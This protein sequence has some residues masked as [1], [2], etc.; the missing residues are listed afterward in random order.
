MKNGKG[1][2]LKRCS[3]CLYLGHETPAWDTP[4]DSY[5]CRKDHWHGAEHPED[6]DE[7]RE[8]SDFREMIKKT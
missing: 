1:K 8:C 3:D 6:L 5:W 2:K 4:Y 7:K